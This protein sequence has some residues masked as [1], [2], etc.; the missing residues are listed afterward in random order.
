MAELRKRPKQGGQTKEKEV[1]NERQPESTPAAPA[2]INWKKVF[3]RVAMGAV[4]VGILSAVVLSD[5][6]ILALFAVIVQVLAFKEI[7]SLRYVEAKERNLKY[8]RSMN[9]FF[10]LGT[11]FYAH[12]KQVMLQFPIVEISRLTRYHT[13]I[14]FIIYVIGFMWF[15]L[16][17]EKETYKYQFG[18]LTWT[19]TTL[20]I[21]IVQSHFFTNDIYEGI[22]WFILP[23]AII[24]ANDIAAYFC[25]LFF[26]RKIINRPFLSLSPNKTW[27]GF[28]GGCFWTIIFGVLFANF[29]S[30][31]E[32]IICPKSDL[33]MFKP[34]HCTPDYPFVPQNYFLPETLA[35]FLTKYLG[36]D[37]S[38]VTF[39]P[40]LFHALVFSLFGS[41]IAP[42]GGFYASGIK[43]AYKVK[44]F[45]AVIPGH[46]GF[47][48]RSDCQFIMGLFLHVYYITFVK[49]EVVDAQRL[50]QAVLTLELRDQ[51]IIYESLGAAIQF[52]KTH[53]ITHIVGG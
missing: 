18:Q 22:I 36:S 16:T 44:D 40:I 28:I 53:N 33:T 7:I 13:W 23:T 49:P 32:W 25:G 31:Y 39:K 24:V 17:L 51:E 3:T 38:Y 19:L 10:L 34:L 29:L 9:W 42:F 37:W 8:F 41:L 27:E 5:H 50:L 47:T 48:D 21:V 52:A 4:M 26:G 43:R 20:L 46:G 14:C 12:G 1:A 2:G 6:A 45:D 30:N 11:L 15:I 35:A